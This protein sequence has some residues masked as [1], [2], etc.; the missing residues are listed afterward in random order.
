MWKK[1]S[2][3]LILF[4]LLALALTLPPVLLLLPDGSLRVVILFVGGALALWRMQVVIKP[5]ERLGHALGQQGRDGEVIA[6]E[7]LEELGQMAEHSNRQATQLKAQ[8]D[9]IKTFE[10]ERG[11]L[12]ARLGLLAKGDV[13]PQAHEE[14]S[15]LE[16]CGHESE[17]IRQDVANVA[18]HVG[19]LARGRLGL[20]EVGEQVVALSQVDLPVRSG[21]HALW[22]PIDQLTSQLRR[23][24]IQSEA[25]AADTL[26]AHTL[27]D[28]VPG[29]LGA[30]LMKTVRSLRTL[31]AVAKEVASGNLSGQIESKGDLGRSFGHMVMH[32]RQ[33]VERIAQMAIHISTSSEQILVV[34]RNQELSASHQASGVEETQ[35]TMETLLSSAKKIAESAQT[36]FKSAER[37]QANNRIISDRA[38][39]LK[40]H[41]ERI[42]EIL[43]SIKEIADRSDLLALNASLEGLRA[44]EAGKSFTLVASEMRRLAETIKGS[45]GDIKS[46]LGDMRASALS[47]VMAIEEGSKLS[48][49]TTDS[50]L[51]ISLITQQQQSGTEQ[52]TQSMEELSLLITQGL[53]GTQQVTTAT[54]ELTH[55]AEDLRQIVETFSLENLPPYRP[56]L[57]DF[58]RRPRYASPQ[59]GVP[60]LVMASPLQSSGRFTHAPSA[61][62]TRPRMLTPLSMGQVSRENRFE[63]QPR[64]DPAGKLEPQDPTTS[65]HDLLQTR[66]FDLTAGSPTID[67]SSLKDDAGV[68]SVENAE[69]L[70]D[71][72]ENHLNPMSADESMERT[73]EALDEESSED[74]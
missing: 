18:E 54:A 47:S 14:W 40:I 61:S 49:R 32:L 27:E 38:S 35:R 8:H 72:L 10:R 48:E 6:L 74:V 9:R 21:A 52:V 39:E 50:A 53:S 4:A 65:A 62:E 2:L 64:R 17:R 58:G 26:H 16:R 36:V 57:Q 43:E 70:F 42:G 45:V 69:R 15:E 34:L 24:A 46:L 11:L 3:P 68:L 23:L 12:A 20:E 67:V 22:Q 29:E 55:L 25:I 31:N 5:L 33:I 59:A 66:A 63:R 56:G 19:R 13:S 44:G 7:G 51:K 73:F 1:L 37:S 60:A 71:E 30:G 41:T 28:A